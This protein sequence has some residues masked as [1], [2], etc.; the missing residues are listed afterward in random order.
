[1]ENFKNWIISLFGLNKLQNSEPDPDEVRIANDHSPLAKFMPLGTYYFTYQFPTDETC[2]K[3]EILSRNGIIG[4]DRYLKLF[5]RGDEQQSLQGMKNHLEYLKKIEKDGFYDYE[6]NPQDDIHLPKLDIML[7]EM[8]IDSLKGSLE[9]RVKKGQL[10]LEKIKNFDELWFYDDE[11]EVARQCL[12]DDLTVLVEH[13]NNSSACTIL[14]VLSLDIEERMKW[15]KRAAEMENTAGM[16][17][18]GVQLYLQGYYKDGFSWVMK[19]AQRGEEMGMLFVALS[20]HYGTFT[21]HDYDQAVY[22]YRKVLKKHK[23]FY[24]ANN[25]G[26]IYAEA[27]CMHTAKKYFTIAN[28]IYHEELKKNKDLVYYSEDNTI[29]FLNNLY[30]SKRLLHIPYALRPKRIVVKHYSPALQRIMAKDPVDGSVIPEDI[31]YE[32][33]ANPTDLVSEDKKERKEAEKLA[34]QAKTETLI[35]TK[36]PETTSNTHAFEDFVFPSY[37]VTIRNTDIFGDQ[38]ELVFLEK[39]AHAELNLFIQNHLAEIRELFKKNGFRF[40]YMPAHTFDINEEQDILGSYAS[41]EFKINDALPRYFAKENRTESKYWT[42]LFSQETLPDDCAGLLH[43]IPN[44]KPGVISQKY[45]YYLMPYSPKTDWNRMFQQLAAFMAKKQLV[46][47]ESREGIKEEIIG[48]PY[49]LVTA[50]YHIH[51]VDERFRHSASY[52]PN[53]NFSVEVEMHPLS[54][55]LYILFLRHSEGIILKELVDYKEELL[56]IYKEVSSQCNEQS[57]DNLV[58]PTKNSTNEKI[59]RIRSDFRKVLEPYNCDIEPFVPMGVKG[60]RYKVA[61]SKEVL[62]VGNK[63]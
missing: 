26:V 32:P 59:S 2:L 42:T 31:N 63:M 24:A 54:K 4:P 28:E 33:W 30:T 16:V 45:N 57:I 29:E 36:A 20:Y 48:K 53:K 5:L 7:Q 60:E 43:Y 23:S 3:K 41:K 22:W 25:L 9:T 15:M 61:A 39:N 18:Y 13:Y 8:S 46:E 49:L 10:V 38:H 55:V 21:P 11:N 40:A 37:E 14:S 62:W 51:I 17:A 1:M 35:A 52:M 19:G 44:A 47:M 34:R 12:V 50:N 27:N 56:S 58:D 6:R